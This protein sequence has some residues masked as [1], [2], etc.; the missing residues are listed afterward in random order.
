MKNKNHYEKCKGSSEMYYIIL[1]DIVKSLKIIKM[2]FRF[3]IVGL[4]EESIPTLLKEL[5]QGGNALS[6]HANR[7]ITEA[8]KTALEQGKPVELTFDGNW[9]GYHKELERLS[10]LLNCS[11]I[12]RIYNDVGILKLVFDNGRCIDTALL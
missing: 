10:G 5:F 8:E 4:L 2:E 1:N 12:L 11:I 9:I 6:L 3:R 7:C